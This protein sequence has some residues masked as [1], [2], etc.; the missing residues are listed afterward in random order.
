MTLLVK[1]NRELIEVDVDQDL[2]RRAVRACAEVGW[3][4]GT[5]TLKGATVAGDK[6]TLRVRRG[7]YGVGA[8]AAEVTVVG[9]AK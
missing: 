2:Y 8:D 5:A 6:I 7:R 3:E 1:S 4:G 9:G